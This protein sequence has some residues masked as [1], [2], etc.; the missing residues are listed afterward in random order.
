LKAC[1]T[2]AIQKFQKIFT[3]KAA[4]DCEDLQQKKAKKSPAE[5]DS[6]LQVEE[7]AREVQLY[8][9]LKRKR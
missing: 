6:D 5:I 8:S 2:N 7:L 9:K 1:N 4:C 3:Q